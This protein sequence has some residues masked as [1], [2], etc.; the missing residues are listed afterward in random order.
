MKIASLGSNLNM[1]WSPDGKYL[2]VGNKSDT[3]CVFDAISGHQLRKRKCSYE[4][5]ELAWTTNAQSLFAATAAQ[6]AGALEV[7]DVEHSDDLAVIHSIVAHSATCFS[8]C[9][10]H[11]NTFN[12]NNNN[13]STNN[14]D[15][16]NNS[17]AASIIY[18]NQQRMAVSSV[19]CCVTLWSCD[20]LVVVRTISLE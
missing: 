9:V 15:N 11:S 8:L 13:N 1:S 4:V 17:N 18:H 10:S 20:D 3:L 14:N 2:A 19:D 12:I 7:I 16:N 6:S 5:N